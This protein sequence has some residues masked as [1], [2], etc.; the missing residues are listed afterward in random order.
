MS[1][2]LDFNKTLQKGIERERERERE[3]FKIKKIR[4]NLILIISDK[5]AVRRSKYTK[6]CRSS[7][8]ILRITL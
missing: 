1:A 6:D 8:I 3:S 2:N 5:C 4:L 7:K